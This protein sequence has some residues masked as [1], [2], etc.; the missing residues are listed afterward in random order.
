MKKRDKGIVCAVVACAILIGLITFRDNSD[1]RSSLIEKLANNSGNV[2]VDE[3]FPVAQTPEGCFANQGFAIF[4]DV[5]FQLYNDNK[6]VLSDFRNG[7]MISRLDIA[8]LHGDTIDFSNEYYSEDD[9][10]P[11]AYITIDTNP[12]TVHVV[13]I[14][15]ESSDLIRVYSFPDIKI[16]GYYAGHCLD[17]ANR[18]LYLVG[19]AN[20]SYYLDDN[21][22]MIVTC[23]DLQSFTENEDKTITPNLIDS[24]TIP[25]IIT[26]QGQ[27]LYQD[28]I[29]LLSSHN[30]VGEIG[31]DTR[32]III[33]PKE[34]R[35]V[36]CFD[37]FPEKIKRTEC[38]G[39]EFVTQAESISMIL[40][41]CDTEAGKYYV[42]Q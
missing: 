12:A 25:F 2:T 11:L 32:I 10:F 41:T 23:W 31:I 18:L 13:R 30:G 21:N 15:R 22:K 8:S 28:K 17:A 29:Y 27:R 5:L 14:T 39:I 34:R 6:I 19:Y 9:E 37:Q 38:E 33:D 35:V 7:A 26:V 24:Y 42:L 20:E 3:L 1:R 4:N 16:T 36:G 40:S